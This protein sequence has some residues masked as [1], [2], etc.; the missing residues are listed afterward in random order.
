MYH[1]SYTF[2]DLPSVK[3]SKH[4]F[5]AIC[6]GPCFSSVSVVT[7]LSLSKCIVS[8]LSVYESLTFCFRSAAVSV[9]RFQQVILFVHHVTMSVYSIYCPAL[10]VVQNL[11][12]L[13]LLSLACQFWRHFPTIRLL[14]T[15]PTHKRLCLERLLWYS[16]Q[17]NA[18]NTVISSP[19]HFIILVHQI[20]V[21]YTHLRTHTK[22]SS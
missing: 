15:F 16:F 7:L 18:H 1:T 6:H 3:F 2:I 22:L 17:G 14:P 4:V 20:L 8:D 9:V 10:N 21:V 19:C 12:V 5:T 11:D 13:Y